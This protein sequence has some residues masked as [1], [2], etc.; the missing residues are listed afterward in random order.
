VR[1]FSVF[2]LGV[3]LYLKSVFSDGQD[4]NYD[5][6]ITPHTHLFHGTKS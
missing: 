2:F 5:R 4:V 1:D 6:D 3:L